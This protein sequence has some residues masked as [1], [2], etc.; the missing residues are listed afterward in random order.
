MDP[1]DGVSGPLI[2]HLKS[3]QLIIYRC[4]LSISYTGV[5]EKVIPAV[6]PF[7]VKADRT[8]I[9]FHDRFQRL[10]VI[11]IDKR[12]LMRRPEQ[13]IQIEKVKVLLI[14]LY[15]LIKVIYQPFHDIQIA[16]ERIMPDPLRKAHIP[17]MISMGIA[18]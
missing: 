11:L 6:E 13:V 2:L 10:L 5:L 18:R 15:Q 16:K 17:T 1:W 14:K 12:H 9:T 7:A 8:L 3:I 4:Q